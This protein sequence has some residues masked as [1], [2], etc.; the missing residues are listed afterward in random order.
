M[1]KHRP[2]VR[3]QLKYNVDTG[4]IEEF[5][6]DDNA[7]AA[8]EAYH[9]KVARAVAGRLGRRPDIDDAGPIRAPHVSHRTVMQD[10]DETEKE[11]PVLESTKRNKA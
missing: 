6:V 7:R 3:I 1:D 5:I 10:D 8:S 4:E 11:K 9:D 2:R